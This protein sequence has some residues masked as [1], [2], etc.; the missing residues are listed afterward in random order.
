MFNKFLISAAVASMSCAAMAAQP[1]YF[2]GYI[3]GHVSDNK[4]DLGGSESF[5]SYGVRASASYVGTQNFG[6]QLDVFHNQGRWQGIDLKFQDI[7]GH[8]YYRNQ[9]YLIGGL[10][11]KSSTGLD[12]LSFT[13]TLMGVEGQYYFDRTTV[14]AKLGNQSLDLPPGFFGP[15]F[16]PSGLFWEVD[17]RYFVTDN[18]RVNASYSKAKLSESGDDLDSTHYSL[19]TEY[20]LQN[21][22]VS[23]F[24]RYMKAKTDFA[25]LGDAE[26]RTF[27]VGVTLNFGGSNSLIERDRKGASLN[28]V[29][30]DRVAN[31]PF[32]GAP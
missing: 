13:S 26:N 12:S 22:N 7:A 6:G 32:F 8:A 24:G 20:R 23:L 18:W 9:Q 29:N 28:P 1:G 10:I 5:T 30:L 3:S 19:G 2:D 16:S 14:G 11:Q 25:G 15:G 21:S 4:I 17:A 27:M 31:L